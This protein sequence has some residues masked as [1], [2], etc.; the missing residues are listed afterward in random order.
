MIIG[1]PKEIKDNEFRVAL[2]PAGVRELTEA[3]HEVI[4][5]VGAGLGSAITDAEFQAAGA[6]MVTRAGEVFSEADIVIKVKEPQ[7]AEFGFLSERGASLILF[8]FF[9]FASDR[10]LFEAVKKS[11][12]A[13]LAYETVTDALGATP[14][15]KPMSAVAG[16]LSIQA[17]AHFLTRP[18][19]GSGVLLGGVPGVAP[20]RVVILGAGVVGM[21]ALEMAVGLGAG[22]TVL[23]NNEERLAHIDAIYGGRVGTLASN[24]FN[25][26]ENVRE[27]DLLI[28][29]VHLPGR[30][31]EK[32]V[33]KEMVKK[34][35]KGS[36]IVD[37]AVDQGGSVETIRP[38]THSEPIYKECGV[39]HYAVT[40]MPGAV[41]RTSTFALTN[42][43]LPY[44]L[45]VANKG[46]KASL[47]ELPELGFGLNIYNGKVTNLA[48]SELYDE[49]FTEPFDAF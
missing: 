10:A 20:G 32:L 45:L 23:D 14:L 11:G 1:V 31:T 13:A 29:A 3:G 42:A 28:G 48:V 5:E 46:L 35:R 38:T 41:P 44:L 49:K 6:R 18:E 39:I 4:V 34:M 43:T 37:V 25:I 47:A 2:T 36:V 7:P 26:E 12:V 21:N 15:L 19:G 22:V 40:N 33:T 16:R 30:R 27:A 9:H 17:G 24:S 8:T